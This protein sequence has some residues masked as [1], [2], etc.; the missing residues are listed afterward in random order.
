ME[1]EAAPFTWTSPEAYTAKPIKELVIQ[2]NAYTLGSSVW[3]STDGGASWVPVKSTDLGRPL[4]VAGGPH[5]V[6][7]RIDNIPRF[8]AG[9][10]EYHL[11][12]FPGPEAAPLTMPGT[13]SAR[14]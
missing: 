2:T 11:V 9:D 10:Y 12:A 8:P 6:M 7:V 4:S 13:G 1:G 5:R 14:R 3:L